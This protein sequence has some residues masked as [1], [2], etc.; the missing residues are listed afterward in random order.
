MVD[1]KIEVPEG[2]YEAEVRDGYEVSSLMKKVWAVEMDLLL[3][4]DRV[5]KKYGLTYFVEGG[6][7]L[8]AV[9]HKGFIPWDDDMDI[10]LPRKDYETLLRVGKREFKHPYFLQSAYSEKTFA[11]CYAKLRNS[12]TTGITKYDSNRDFNHGI[13]I[14]IFG[15]DSVPDNKIQ[16]A[17]WLLQVKLCRALIIGWMY[18]GK[19]KYP[20]PE[21]I[22][23]ILAKKITEKAGKLNVYRRLES[24]ITRYDN[25]MTKNVGIIGF[26]CGNKRFIW[27]RKCSE[28]LHNAPFEFIEVPIP[29][30]YD[31]R[32]R[33][34]FGDYMTPVKARTEHG[35][36]TFDVDVPYYEYMEKHAGTQASK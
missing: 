30:G 8:G 22:A 18:D 13:F 12:L 32:L 28:T 4:L 27:P 11:K 1:L 34:D 19:K 9:R 7:L 15:Y 5:C 14:D 33:I 10:V 2:Y 23:R 24:I 3:E 31:E 16:K 20:L 17:L 25:K 35:S 29:D 26:G 21:K 36:M 6:T